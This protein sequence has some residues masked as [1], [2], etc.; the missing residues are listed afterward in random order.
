MLET[1][2]PSKGAAG[3]DVVLQELWHAKDTLSAACGHDLKR[4]LAEA[5]EHQKRALHIV[6]DF[7]P[8][9]GETDQENAGRV[10]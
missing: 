6:V 3:G 10:R 4:M 1:T 8:S 5:R 7:S 2:N 9:A